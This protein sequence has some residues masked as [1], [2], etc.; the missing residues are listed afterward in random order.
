L[1]I[2]FVRVANRLRSNRNRF[3]NCPARATE[4]VSDKSGTL[5]LSSYVSRHNANGTLKNYYSTVKYLKNFLKK[6]Y[7]ASDIYLKD[8]KYEFIT[9]FEYFLRNNPI[10]KNDPC[11]N[12]GTMKHLDRLKKM[13][14]WAAKHEWIEKDHFKHFQLKFKRTERDGG[15]AAG[16][17]SWMA[18]LYRKIL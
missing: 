11:T 5:S 15:N 17:S 18:I 1:D 6:K 12:N 3:E 8:L 7:N 13:V 10:R 4:K 9:A 14:N 16:F 2:Q